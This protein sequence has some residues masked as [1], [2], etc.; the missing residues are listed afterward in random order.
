M[1]GL[2]RAPAEA[3]GMFVRASRDFCS[4]AAIL[5]LAWFCLS[6][7]GSLFAQP[8][9]TYVDWTSAGNGAQGTLGEIA[10]TLSWSSGGQLGY[11]W[12]NNNATLFGSDAFSPP[13]GPTDALEIRGFS[14]APTYT[15]TFSEPVTNVVLHLANLGSELHFPANL[16]PIMASGD[17]RFSVSGQLVKGEVFNSEEGYGIDGN[18]TI[19]F[20][21]ALTSI[22]FNAQ[23]SGAVDG[24]AIQVGAMQA[25]A[26]VLVGLEA[27]QVIQDWKNSVPLVAGKKTFVRA[28]LEDPSGPHSSFLNYRLLGFGGPNLDQPLVPPSVSFLDVVDVPEVANFAARVV[29]SKSIRFELPTSWLTASTKRFK[30][31][32]GDGLGNTPTNCADYAPPHSN[33]CSV[34]V[35]FSERKPMVLN[36]IR[37]SFKHGQTTYRTTNSDLTKVCSEVGRRF[38][39]DQFAC[40]ADRNTL[41]I[42]PGDTLPSA[43]EILDLVEYRKWR[44]L[45]SICWWSSCEDFYIAVT[46]FMACD[47]SLN[48][49]IGGLAGSLNSNAPWHRSAWS[50]RSQRDSTAAPHELGHGFRIDHP[51]KP[52]LVGGVKKGTCREVAYSVSYPPGNTE[53][54]PYYSG[55][56]PLLGP[57]DNNQQAV[58][59][60]DTV[61]DFVVPH[62]SNTLMSYC[63]PQSHFDTGSYGA[64]FAAL[65]PSESTAAGLETNTA[66]YFLVAGTVDLESSQ[67]VLKPVEVF[68]PPFTP[69][70]PPANSDW[71]LLVLKGSGAPLILPLDVA[72]VSDMPGVARFDAFVEFDATITGFAVRYN[73]EVVTELSATGNAPGIAITAPAPGADFLAQDIELHWQAEDADGDPLSFTVEYSPDNGATWTLLTLGWPASPFVVNSELIQPSQQVLFRVTAL[74]GFHSTSATLAGTITVIQNEIHE[75]GFE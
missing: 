69:P 61:L 8:A 73:G 68:L 29:L 9:A 40:V 14:S 24:I 4:T 25:G 17:S 47:E 43:K 13:M 64:I 21:G 36:L 1:S 6:S 3:G 10:V 48:C 39:A 45:N 18:G 65:A 35:E 7:P 57:L 37:T 50:I 20:Q 42:P 11:A 27:V 52:P 26:L 33:D 5:L 53:F 12:L 67:A 30:L 34:T 60:Y 56:N 2:S 58:F 66:E 31:E 19:R 59:G 63:S 70:G 44:S 75:D 28:H 74:D 23:H 32:P 46:D 22:S 15:I 72:A 51:S 55:N 71:E 41:V 38:P 16:K 54:Y 62:S 49:N